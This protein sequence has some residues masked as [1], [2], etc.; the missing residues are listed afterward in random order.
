MKRLPVIYAVLV[1]AVLSCTSQTQDGR[2]DTNS[3]AVN[4]GLKSQKPKLGD[5]FIYWS[6]G[7]SIN[8]FAKQNDQ[9][10]NGFGLDSEP[11]GAV[12]AKSPT[13]LNTDLTDAVFAVPIE[14]LNTSD[15]DWLIYAV[16]PSDCLI[17][18]QMSSVDEIGRASCRERV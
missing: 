9:W 10:I 6:S 7:E 4:I 15:G 17:D 5:S 18:K 2:D 11:S 1:S 3:A 16:S 12:F 13:V 14:L 8:V